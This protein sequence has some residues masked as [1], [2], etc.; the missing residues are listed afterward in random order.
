MSGGASRSFRWR[1]LLAALATASAILSTDLEFAG[2]PRV[3]SRMISVVIRYTGVAPAELE[4]IVTEPLESRL[5]AVSGLKALRS[6]TEVG[7]VRVNATIRRDTPLDE[8]YAEI[9]DRVDTLYEALPRAVQRPQIVRGD[10][11]ATAI[12][13]IA[14]G[15]DSLSSR[16]V[17]RLADDE[18]SAQLERIAGVAEARVT[19]GAVEEIHVEVDSAMLASSLL[20][21]SEVSRQLGDRHA[22]RAG[23]TL[24]EGALERP[25]VLDTRLETPERLESLLLPPAES[26]VRMDRFASVGRRARAPESISRVD[27]ESTV[28]I[29]ATAT[30]DANILSTSRAAVELAKRWRRQHSVDVSVVHNTGHEAELALRR[31]GTALAASLIAVLLIVGAA[32][33]SAARAFDTALVLPISILF[34]G[35]IVSGIGRPI[36]PPM[37]AGVAVSCGLVVDAAIVLSGRHASASVRA[38]GT[39][40]LTTVAALAPFLLYPDLL[41]GAG[42][43]ALAAALLV[44][45]SFPAAL[46]LR[47]CE[48]FARCAGESR[49]V[50]TDFETKEARIAGV[51]Q[52]AGAISARVAAFSERH[53]APL[54]AVTSVMVAAVALFAV[55]AGSDSQPSG[56]DG[57]LRLHAEFE[58]GA[59]V[60]SVDRRTST[61]AA[62]LA[63]VVE[64][65]RADYTARRDNASI[66]LSLSSD[67][68]PSDVEP[69]VESI[70]DRIA[71]ARLHL[72]AGETTHRSG[73]AIEVAVTGPERDKTRTLAS[74]LADTLMGAV[75]GRS[76]S[77]DSSA[78]GDMIPADAVVLHFK[79][80]PPALVVHPDR[81]R[82]A[83]AGISPAVA[84]RT[85]RWALHGPVVLKWQEHGGETDVRLRSDRGEVRA[86]QQL[87]AL[88]LLR[89]DGDT[90]PLGSV[91]E[92]RRTNRPSRIDRYNRQRASFLTV[93]YPTRSLERALAYLRAGIDAARLPARYAVQLDPRY[94]ERLRR[95]A[96]LWSI[97]L[98]TTIAIALLI[99]AACESVR[100]AA[101]SLLA[102]PP[103]VAITLSPF[104]IDGSPLSA[105]VLVGAVMLAGIAVN[106]AILIGVPALSAGIERAITA[107]TADLLPAGITTVAAAIPLLTLTGATA[108]D[109][110]GESI[111]LVLLAGTLANTAVTYLLLPAIWTASIR[112]KSAGA[113]EANA[114]APPRAGLQ[115]PTPPPVQ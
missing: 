82:L 91:G 28:L 34:T 85:L 4:R 58:S 22:L 115:P 31:T 51:S 81:R 59:S 29:H 79:N 103:T 114:G 75:V 48:L 12:V 110:L 11:E 33:R 53:P 8:A 88:P 113:A 92:L 83:A 60:R 104:L 54:I 49:A 55:R 21:W 106:N 5:A 105:G 23:G 62:E 78:D 102:I 15:G 93:S 89:G 96:H 44:T 14:L 107:R 72:P 57:T 17:R 111:A 27:G 32:A 76:E 66:S 50:G 101:L 24:R 67:T 84:G 86:P 65:D 42:S 99:A 71:D 97:L 73:T 95:Y 94:R 38:V 37:L 112:P 52:T 43:I 20:H 109:A 68:S 69:F 6:S 19:G 64:V 63:S 98:A 87:L 108:H 7:R 18:L 39:S 77:A 30:S 61:I 100:V 26:A 35:A 25:V 40:T 13:V 80:D 74:S 45:V 2:V 70:D 90:V 16:D 36:D 56:H 10:T 3:D 41:P 47:K 46:L 1:V 9:S